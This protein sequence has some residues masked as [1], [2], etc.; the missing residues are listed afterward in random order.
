MRRVICL[1]LVLAFCMYLPCTAFATQSPGDVAPDVPGTDDVPKTGDTSGM[2]LWLF[3]MLIS[4][5]ALVV[6]SVCFRK[7]MR[8]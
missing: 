6:V 2:Y 8:H 4:L 7:V 3:V 5:L 1:L